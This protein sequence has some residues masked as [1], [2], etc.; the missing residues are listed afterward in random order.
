MRNKFYSDIELH[1]LFGVKLWPDKFD[2][3]EV[4]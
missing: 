2:V 1:N 4:V 3:F